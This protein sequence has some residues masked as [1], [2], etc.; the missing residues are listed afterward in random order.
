MRLLADE[1][2]DRLLVAM[3]RDAGHDVVYVAEIASGESD[4]ELMIRARIEGRT[5]LTDDRDFGLLVERGRDR[6]PAVILLRL[7][8]LGRTARARRVVDVLRSLGDAPVSAL[9]VI[10]PGQVRQRL[11]PR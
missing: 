1:N 6:P 8:P 5:I 9:M 11:Y 10:E 7:D 2:C 3:L 4:A